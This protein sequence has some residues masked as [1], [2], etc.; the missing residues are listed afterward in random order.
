MLCTFHQAIRA[1][2]LLCSD[3]QGHWQGATVEGRHPAVL[4]VKSGLADRV[5]Q[6]LSG[7][8]FAGK[9]RVA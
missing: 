8:G 5:R 3:L 4:I 2:N 7:S 6:S 1:R 9:W